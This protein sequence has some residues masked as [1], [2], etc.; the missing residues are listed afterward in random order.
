MTEIQGLESL[1]ETTQKNT[2]DRA[3][4]ARRL[5]EAYVEL[6]TAAFRDKTEAEIKRDDA[7]EDE[8][9]GRRPAAEP[10]RTRPMRS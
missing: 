6:E 7:E 1:F 2:P 3:E 4:L 5:A 10:Q 9:G 8:P